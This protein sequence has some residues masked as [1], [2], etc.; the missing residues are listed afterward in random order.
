LHVGGTEA[1]DVK[2]SD[3]LGQVT[4]E[5]DAV[6]HVHE[7]RRDE[8]NGEAALFHPLVAE[9]KKIAVQAGEAADF[10]LK[11]LRNAGFEAP[12]FERG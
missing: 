5:G 3:A 10:E 12:L 7:L 1:V 4:A 8:P 6:V 11:G 9:Q 2:Q